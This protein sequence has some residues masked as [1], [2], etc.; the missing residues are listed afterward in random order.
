MKIETAAL[1]NEVLYAL[2]ILYRAHNI[3]LKCIRSPTPTDSPIDPLKPLE[4]ADM[5][6]SRR[7]ERQR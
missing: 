7:F 1:L 2:Y 6:K 3:F 4:E 5:K